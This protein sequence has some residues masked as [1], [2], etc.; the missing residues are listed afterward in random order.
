MKYYYYYLQASL[1]FKQ[2]NLG[3]CKAETVSSLFFL[4]KSR[5]N[6]RRKLIGGLKIP[7]KQR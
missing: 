6:T 3:P 5:E 2:V 4:N 7:E 1:V